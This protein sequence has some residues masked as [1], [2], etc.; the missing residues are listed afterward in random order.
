VRHESQCA[1]A[2]VPAELV[3]KH[4]ADLLESSE[5]ASSKRCQ[6]FLQYVVQETIAERGENI[7]ERN[8]A[9]EVFHKSAYFEPSE[10][11]L[12]R[13]KAREVRKRL[14]Q[15]YEAHPAAELKIE[16]PVGSYVPR[17]ST[18][19]KL[20]PA[21]PVLEPA[22]HA[23]A[24]EPIATGKVSRRRTLWM[25]GGA[26]GAA[27]VAGSAVKY[28][29][30][31]PAAVDRLWKPV[32]ATA[33][34]L[35]IFI[36]VLKGPNGELTD[37]IGLGTAATVGEAASF[38]TRRGQRY[39]L[40]FGEALTFAQMRDQPCLLLGGF[41]SSWM[42]WAT[43][44]LRYNLILNDNWERA[45]IRDSVTGQKW[46]PVNLRGDGYA[47]VD[48]GIV[49]RQFDPR[50]G[51][52]LLVAAG[53]T[54]FGTEGA[55]TVLFDPASFAS[56]LQHAPRDWEQRNFEAVVKVSILGTTASPAQVV[57]T[58]FW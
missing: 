29:D 32:F 56:A 8:I 46:I 44:G 36:P 14:T 22:P 23:A 13:V 28:L 45:F 20:D 9:H 18:P 2:G 19:P 53:I 51:Q 35:L 10:D 12:V 39:T 47:D 37:H 42:I 21:P 57:A 38:L 58:H 11:S 16:L 43:Q 31:T 40:R 25:M 49:S 26:F 3:R 17:F 52:I 5:F 15:F 7:K 55:A 30:R 27:V 33:T 48:Y 4:L 54:T 50:T 24:M 41:S 34:P 6:E 1:E